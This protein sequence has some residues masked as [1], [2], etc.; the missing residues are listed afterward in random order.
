VK[1]TIQGNDKDAKEVIR[2]CRSTGSQHNGQK[3]KGNQI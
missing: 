3:K 2:S 1:Y